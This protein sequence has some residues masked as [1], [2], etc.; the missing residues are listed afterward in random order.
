MFSTQALQV[1][2]LKLM[3]NFFDDTDSDEVWP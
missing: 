3:W 2:V 1:L